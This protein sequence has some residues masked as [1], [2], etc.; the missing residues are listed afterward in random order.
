MSAASRLAQRQ[1][2]GCMPLCASMDFPRHSKKAKY[3]PRHQ[4][5]H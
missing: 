1:T 2:M 3:K 5:P 4:H